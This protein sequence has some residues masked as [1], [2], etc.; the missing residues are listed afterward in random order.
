MYVCIYIYINICNAEVTTTGL[1]PSTVLK[2]TLNHLAKLSA[3]LEPNY[4]S[5]FTLKCVRD[6]I[7]T[8]SQS[9]LL[10]LNIY[11]PTRKHFLPGAWL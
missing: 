1:E 5:R 10:T 4:Y 6:M 7:I 11:F 2:R 9:V 3:K 8:Y